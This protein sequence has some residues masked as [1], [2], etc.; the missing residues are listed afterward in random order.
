MPWVGTGIS[1]TRSQRLQRSRP[2]SPAADGTDPYRDDR[3]EFKV[4]DGSGG[5]DF[6]KVVALQFSGDK[7]QL[8]VR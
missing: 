1:I 2:G 8:R 6:F 3:Y 7:A 4:S 5:Y